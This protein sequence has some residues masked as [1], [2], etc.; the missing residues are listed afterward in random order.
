MSNFVTRRTI[1]IREINSILTEVEHLPTGAQIIHIANDDDENVFNLSFQTRPKTSNGV[2]HILEHIVL[3]GSKKFPVKDPFFSMQ[4]RSLNTF[5]NAMTGSDFTCYPAA[6]QSKKDFYNLLE[7]YLDAVFYPNLTKLSF[8]QE[9]HRLEFLKI[10]DPNSPLLFQGVVYNE[11]KGA[12]ATGDAKLVEILM[13][14]LFPNITYG[15]NSG[16]NPKEI[17][18]LTY[19]ELKEFHKTFY[20]PSRCLFY[21]Y[22]NIPL[23]EHLDFIEKYALVNVEKLPQLPLI[24]KQPRLSE[25]KKLESTYP[26]TDR[27][28]IENKT[29]IGMSWLTC[30]ILDQETLLALSLIDV[31]LMGTDAAPLKQVLLKS[32]LCKQVDSTIDNEISEVP[33]T[34]VC[35]G[36]KENA[37]DPIY[38]LIISTLQKLVKEGLPQNLVEGAIHQMEMSRTEITS[39]ST[40]YGLH[41]FFRSGLLKQHG[42]NPEDGLRIH[43]LFNKIRQNIQDPHYLTN[44]IEEYLINNNHFVLVTMRPD[45]NQMKVE[46]EEEKNT[47]KQISVSLKDCDVQNILKQSQELE[48]Q[49]DEKEPLEL[50][51]K[52]TLKDVAKDGKEFDLHKESIYGWDLFSHTCFTNGMF[53]LD[54][55]F[56]LPRISQEELVYLRIFTFLLAQMGCGGRSYQEYLDYLLEHTGGVV[57]SLDLG[58]QADCLSFRP[59]IIIHGKSLNR[60]VEKLLKILWDIVVSTN[61]Q[62][63]PRIKELLMQHLNGIENSI[64]HNALRYAI[65]L[66]ASG[67]S[68]P[69]TIINSW[70]GLDYFWALKNVIKEFEKNPNILIDKLT[71]IQNRSL[72]IKNGKLIL[73]CEDKILSLLKNEKFY[74]LEEIRLKE[75]LKWS[76][77]YKINKTE[78]QGRV[79][80]S[81]VAFTVMLFTSVPYIHPYAAAIST[82]SQIMENKILHTLIRER[83][84]AYGTGAV[85]SLLSGQFYFYSYR[86]P[87]L[88]TSVK[89]FYDALDMITRGDFDSSDIEEAK[90]ELFQDLDSPVSPG[91]RAITAY[92]RLHGNRTPQIRQQF[93]EKL[94]S[95]SKEDIEKAVKEFLAPNIKSAILTS[96]AGKELLEKEQSLLEKP[97]PIYPIE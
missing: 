73:N 30:S 16:G 72:C 18:H 3:C 66:A 71:E 95:L 51:P 27:N 6:S 12:L 10:K 75:F 76:N 47:L 32:N 62:D 57:A 70:Y 14:F 35:K 38:Q 4:R 33:F 96:F 19:E 11:M 36:C 2:A 22:G 40:P 56:E 7:V 94:F 90:L 74:G 79:I 58:L 31:V 1:E 82:A 78:S 85:S 92:C 63:V 23:K 87:N 17:P 34:I 28:D 69:S 46:K 8:L 80:A 60:K 43:S 26:V 13:Q 91:S 77:D 5:M 29:L 86:D 41:L 45:L 48:S 67:L 15:V 83:G 20:H 21:F 81:P 53:Y 49:H 59:Y 68:V 44:L 42:G 84:G 88:H 61:F 9:G 54:I 50:L 37:G 52:V 25:K 64:Q 39:D 65:N 93:R 24:P 97:F 89:A 55:I